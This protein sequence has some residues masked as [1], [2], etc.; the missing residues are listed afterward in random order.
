MSMEHKVSLNFV[1]A[2]QMMKEEDT[3]EEMV[4]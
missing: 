4:L 2:D 3:Y 1:F